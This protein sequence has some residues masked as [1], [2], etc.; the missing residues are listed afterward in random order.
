MVAAMRFFKV[1]TDEAGLGP[2]LGPLVIAS[3]ACTSKVAQPDLL[4]LLAEVITPPNVRDKRLEVGDSKLVY[5]GK[6]KMRRLERTVLATVAWCTQKIPSSIAEL[7]T[8]LH[9]PELNPSAGTVWH[10]AHP[11]FAGGALPV[12]CERAEIELA[13]ASLRKVAAK[14]GIVAT[15]YHADIVSEARLN[16]ENEVE[17]EA[18]GSKNTWSTRLL[19]ANACRIAQSKLDQTIDGCD[20]VFDRAGGRS[21]YQSSIVEALA[22]LGHDYTIGDANRA[23]VRSSYLLRSKLVS[24]PEVSMSFEVGADHKHATVAWAS[25][26]AKYLRELA[27][28]Q[29][30][31]HY[32]RN[33]PTLKATAGYP[34]DANR[35]LEDAMKLGV[36]LAEMSQVVRGV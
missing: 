16:A 32:Q 36:P 15:H 8:L 1:G 14:A 11:Q 24:Y 28:E 33:F 4:Q 20:L 6:H 30:N 35:W 23:P 27:M 12:A 34:Q 22:V 19:L 17:R 21:D 29:F 13:A 2:K 26:L 18:G 5:Q 25:M 3:F 7:Y 10:P 31:A 9:V